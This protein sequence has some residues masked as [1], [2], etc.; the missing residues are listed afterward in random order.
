MFPPQIHK[1]GNSEDEVLLVFPRSY[2]VH[3]STTSSLLFRVIHI[4][5]ELVRTVNS[6]PISDLLSQNLHFIKV[7]LETLVS[8]EKELQSLIGEQH[9]KPI[10][11]K[12]EVASSSRSRTTV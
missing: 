5:G 9:N 1:L 11:V 10:R 8:T 2:Q 3:F 4:T 6:G 12:I 7:A